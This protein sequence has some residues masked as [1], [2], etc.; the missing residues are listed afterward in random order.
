MAARLNTGGGGGQPEAGQGGAAEAAAQ[1]SGPAIPHKG[2]EAAHGVI[3]FRNGL[4]GL[5]DFDHMQESAVY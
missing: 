1:G 4:A 3:T 2:W 5:V